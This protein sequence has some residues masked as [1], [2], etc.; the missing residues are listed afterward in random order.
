[1]PGLAE[2]RLA[3]QQQGYESAAWNVVRP[4]LHLVAASA[5]QA[6]L[7]VLIHWHRP[8]PVDPECLKAFSCQTE[9]VSMISYKIVLYM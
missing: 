9:I 2:V 5:C 7:P 6:E 8:E 3:N 1:M 4:Y